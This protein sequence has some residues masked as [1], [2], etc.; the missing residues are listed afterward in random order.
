M[1]SGLYQ[2]RAADRETEWKAFEIDFILNIVRVA[3]SDKPH[4]LAK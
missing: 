1:K 2:I 4:A 3:M